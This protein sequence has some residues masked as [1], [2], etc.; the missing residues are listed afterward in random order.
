MQTEYIFGTIEIAT[1]ELDY[2]GL[3]IKINEHFVK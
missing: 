1:R 3:C 2:K